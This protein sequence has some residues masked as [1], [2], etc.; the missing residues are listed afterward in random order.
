M[1]TYI[2]GCCDLASAS[3]TIILMG[4]NARFVDLLMLLTMVME[5]KTQKY[6]YKLRFPNRFRMHAGSGVPCNR[7]H[8]HIAS[9]CYT[10]VTHGEVKQQKNEKRKFDLSFD[11]LINADTSATAAAATSANGI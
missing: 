7:I 4:K 10:A 11:H 9:G 8:K 2:Y 6:T 5:P 3:I 1:Y